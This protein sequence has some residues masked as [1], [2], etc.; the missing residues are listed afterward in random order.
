M[1][2]F[3]LG[4]YVPYDSWVHRMDPRAKIFAMIALMVAVF[5]TYSTWTMTYT[6]MGILLL[7]ISII[8]LFTHMRI[9]DFLSSL[10]SMWIMVIILLVIYVLVPNQNPTVGVAFSINGYKVYWDSFLEAGRILLRLFMMI[11]LTMIL[12]A[13]TKPLD[14]TYALEWYMTP[15]KAIRFPA[16]EIAMTVSIAL[17]FIPT[18]LE[19]A[20]RVM[21]AQASRGVDF[22]HG[23]LGRR[24]VG[25]TSL[26]IP[27]FVSSFMRSEELANAMECRCYDP[28]AKRTRYRKLRFRW[29]DALGLLVASAVA[30]GIIVVAAMRLDLYQILFG[31][32]GLK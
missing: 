12:T 11:E 32:G 4:R 19:D 20:M 31:I 30:A 10:R 2:K 27:L 16:A 29:S 21:K 25:L 3:A 6:M 28:R 9:V 26:I 5:F 1:K 7:F 15:L 24:I 17:R 13:T 14:L 22:K 8:L 23:G 18:L